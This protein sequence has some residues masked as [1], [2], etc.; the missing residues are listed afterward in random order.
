MSLLQLLPATALA[1]ALMAWDA[2]WV[3]RKIESWLRALRLPL[4]FLATLAFQWFAHGGAESGRATDVM[5]LS[6][7]VVGALALMQAA[8]MGPIFFQ[9]LRPSVPVERIAPARPLV[10]IPAAVVLF[11]GAM[12]A[13]GFWSWSVFVVL[14]LD[15]V[16]YAPLFSL[17]LPSY[18][19]EAPFFM[20]ESFEAHDGPH[21]LE[22]LREPDPEP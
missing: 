2:V 22:R 9:L 14:G 7:R 15:L 6:I 4:I 5:Q 13:T 19:D 1:G 8:V 3:W 16:M 17:L 11:V 18:E 20:S 12:L 21:I 10:R